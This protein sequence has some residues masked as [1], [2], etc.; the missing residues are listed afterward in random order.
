MEALSGA[1]EDSL[2]VRNGS[3]APAAGV[4]FEGSHG[5]WFTEPAA[6]NTGENREALDAGSA[7]AGSAKGHVYTPE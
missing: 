7:V 1:V 5:L 2:H 3:I 4:I 6:D